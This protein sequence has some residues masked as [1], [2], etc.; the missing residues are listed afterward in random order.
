M[1]GVDKENRQQFEPPSPPTPLPPKGRRDMGLAL[2]EPSHW[3]SCST[4]R[5]SSTVVATQKGDSAKF[6]I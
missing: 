4:H 1:V 3:R 5:E 6:S 2:K